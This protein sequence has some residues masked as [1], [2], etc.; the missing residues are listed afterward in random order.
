M[1]KIEIIKIKIKTNNSNTMRKKQRHKH[2]K[3]E[4]PNKLSTSIVAKNLGIGKKQIN[5][6]QTQQ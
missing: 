4:I 1:I 2:T 6:A 3:I 5:W